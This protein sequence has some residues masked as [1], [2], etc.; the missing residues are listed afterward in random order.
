MIVLFVICLLAILLDVALGSVV[1][2]F[3]E[4]LI[5]LTGG[6]ASNPTWTT[7]VFEFRMPRVLAAV[8]VGSGLAA[9]G[10]LMQ[11][12][13]RNPIA[14]PY[15][16]GISSG[17]SLGV[18]L[19]LMLGGVF[20]VAQVGSWALVAVAALGSG[21]VLLLMLLIAWRVGDMT[22]LLIVGLMIGSATSAIVTIL[23]YFSGLQQ[24]KM[25][26]L[27]SMGSLT[28]ITWAELWVLF[29]IIIIGLVTAI[30]LAKPLNGWLLGEDYARSMGIPVQNIRFIIISVTA[31]LAGSIT[32]FC[33]PIAFVG[34]AVPHIARMLLRSQNH[35]VLMPVSILLGAIVLLLCDVVAQL[36][37]S[38][39]QLPINAVTSLVGA[40]V[41]IWIVIQ[42]R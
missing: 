40:P 35:L 14:G 5:I 19:L 26:V 8:L 9:S 34:I 41:V 39:Q 1:I 25:F 3:R 11:T 18:A 6:E 28:R 38:A 16:L 29:V 21:L 32:A 42:R 10:L 4:L 2:P 24:L 30:L 36:P 33:G 20:A 7:I 31:L 37:G 23:E 22:T 13:F 27:W 15:I 12:L 17:A